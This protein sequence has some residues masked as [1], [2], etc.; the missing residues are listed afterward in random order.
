MMKDQS[1]HYVFQ[2]E[3]GLYWAGYELVDQLR[4][5][6]L[7]NSLKM[8]KEQGIAAVKRNRPISSVGTKYRLLMIEIHVLDE[9]NWEVIE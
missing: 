7:Y 1:Y 3:N 9:G 8:A 5:A 4:K 6:K 2:L